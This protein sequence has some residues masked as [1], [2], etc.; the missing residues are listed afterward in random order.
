M[1][2]SPIRNY[3][4][5][6]SVDAL[7]RRDDV[8]PLVAAHGRTVVTEAIREVVEAMRRDRP[9]DGPGPD[10]GPGPAD[11]ARR[12]REAV[13]RRTQ[14]TL[15]VVINATGVVVH[16]NLG[17]A[18]LSRAARVAMDRAAAR[19]STLEYDLAEGERGS[20]S[21]RLERQLSALFPGHAS[22]AVNNNASAVYLALRALAAGR[23]VIL[24]RGEMV[25]IGGSF[26]V[27]DMMAESGARLREV[28]TTNRTR[29]SDYEKALGPD[30]ALL[31]KVHPSNYRIVGFTMEATT[32]DLAGLARS[33]G[34]PLIVDQGSGYL[35]PIA[36]ARLGDEPTVEQF[37]SQGADLVTFSGDKLLGGPQAGIAVGRPDLIERMRRS[38]LYRVLRLDKTTL[39]ALESTLQ[40]YLMG[41]ERDDVPVLR[42]I[43]A[44]REDLTRRAEA[45]A[46]RL[47][48]LLDPQGLADVVEG[49]SRTGGG[50]APELDLPTS[51]VRLRPGAAGPAV[52]AWEA[53]LRHAPVPV[54]ARVREDAL[55]LDPRTVDPSEED[56]LVQGVAWAMERAIRDPNGCA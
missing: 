31:L 14:A 51:L 55:W 45:I 9:G 37:L 33:R 30:T 46:A 41:V 15:R 49:A 13:S 42:M 28:G 29:L 56:D 25:E 3:R 50:S 23:E 24:S 48:E 22:L 53:W 19:Y 26:R 7:L 5:I 2:D 21:A 34:I 16:T 8:A 10:D 43:L 40:A 39:A 54:V 38:P 11:V 12:V 18:P 4:Q 47:A 20:R 32:G 17:R 1:T 44:S 27:P 52:A 36:G 35:K 6:P